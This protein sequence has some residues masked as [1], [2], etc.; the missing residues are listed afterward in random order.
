M[1]GVSLGQHIG[2]SMPLFKQRWQSPALPF[3]TVAPITPTHAHKFLIL[4]TTS[5][6]MNCCLLKS[7][8]RCWHIHTHLSALTSHTLIQM[9]THL[10]AHTAP[11][12]HPPSHNNRNRCVPVRRPLRLC[13]RGLGVAPGPRLGIGQEEER[14]AR[15]GCQGQRLHQRQHRMQFGRYVTNEET[16]EKSRPFRGRAGH[17]FPFSVPLRFGPPSFVL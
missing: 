8:T 6:P 16:D 9:H 11:S 7:C 5:P 1:C 3:V 2:E 17:D 14:R 4:F 12:S 15:I 10:R 13:P